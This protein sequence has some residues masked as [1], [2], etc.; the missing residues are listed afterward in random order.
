MGD[1]TAEVS[2]KRGRIE[3]TDLHGEQCLVTAVAPLSERTTFASKLKSL[4]ASAGSYE[5]AVA[6]YELT[7]P[8]VQQSIMSAFKPRAEEGSSKDPNALVARLPNDLV[9]RLTPHLTI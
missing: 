2:G 8:T 9:Q 7:P 5:M 3:G 4:T 1:I 6:H